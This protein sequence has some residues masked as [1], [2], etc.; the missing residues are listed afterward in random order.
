ML[1]EGDRL[2]RRLKGKVALVTGGSTGLGAEIVQ[3]FTDSGAVVSIVDVKAP[4]QG[5]HHFTRADVSHS[6][7]FTAAVEAVIED[8]GKLDIIVNNAAIQPHGISLEDTTPELLDKVFHI[9]SHAVF[10]GLQLAK[11][12]MEEGGSVIN[13]SSFVGSIGAP[14]CPSY[15]ASKAAVDHLT[16]VGAIELA[17]KQITV[18]AVAP[19]LVLTPAVTS[20][21]NNPEV[22][23]VEDRT[24]LGR[25]AVPSDI[26]PL[27]EFLASDEA[28][29]IT[30]AIIPVDGGISAGWNRYDLRAPEE[31]ADGRWRS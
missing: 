20:I 14:N 22:P 31:W 10:F 5:D 28:R 13:T 19:G 17:C 16:R 15:A 25:A 1:I 18:N 23:F 12:Y 30:G 3:R 27:F 21:L 7:A 26:A 11:L 6:E 8:I 29:F 24:P 2:E 4:A 9:N